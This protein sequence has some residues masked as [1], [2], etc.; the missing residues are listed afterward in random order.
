M[1]D[2]TFRLYIAKDTSETGRG[3]I[4]VRFAPGETTPASEEATS[5]M[6]Y[7]K[8]FV[9]GENRVYFY[10]ENTK[11]QLYVDSPYMMSES[12]MKQLFVAYP[13]TAYIFA[14][15][16]T[17]VEGVITLEPNGELG[18]FTWEWND[19]RTVAR[20]MPTENSKGA[21]G[22]IVIYFEDDG[23][24]SASWGEATPVDATIAEA[25]M[26]EAGE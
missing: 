24:P 11:M 20:L 14:N 2:N 7:R 23:I 9:K 8:E 26:A 18:G 13:R 10:R 6:V 4:F 17:R 16:N 3:E 12:D 5:S 15:L 22:S 1:D 25:T 19:D 21:S